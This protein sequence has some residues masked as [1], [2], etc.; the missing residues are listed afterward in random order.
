MNFRTISL[1]G[2]LVLILGLTF[3]PAGKSAVGQ[4]PVPP[5]FSYE[6]T[7]PL[8]PVTFSHKFHVTDKKL[9]CGDC[10]INPKIFD[11][12]KLSA[13]PKM[14]MVTLNEGKF[15][16]TCHNGGKSFETKDPKNCVKCHV[17]K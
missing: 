1:M 9:Q 16:G 5:D 13:S 6:E 14:T 3:W 7:K 11:M 8:P 2:L 17:K 15:C 10:H 4:M 12:K